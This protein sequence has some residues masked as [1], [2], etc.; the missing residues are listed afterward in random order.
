MPRLSDEDILVHDVNGTIG[1]TVN[2]RQALQRGKSFSEDDIPIWLEL[3]ELKLARA[4]SDYRNGRDS[5]ESN[6]LRE[7]SNSTLALLRPHLKKGDK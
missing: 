6:A 7:R 5:K 2:V 1:M 4:V 3:I